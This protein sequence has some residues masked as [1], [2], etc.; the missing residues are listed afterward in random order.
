MDEGGYYGGSIINVGVY[1]SRGG[2][3]SNGE[4]DEA[5]CILK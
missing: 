3:Y 4:A 5:Y 2:C 1:D